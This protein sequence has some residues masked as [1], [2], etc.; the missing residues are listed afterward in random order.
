MRIYKN[1]FN[2][3]IQLL[4][5]IAILLPALM[6]NYKMFLKPSCMALLVY[7]VIF[8]VYIG[9]YKIKMDTP[10]ALKNKIL[11]IYSCLTGLAISVGN[12]I[13]FT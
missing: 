7:M 5:V 10:L 2:L 12:N 9:R 6:Q 13:E 3:V 4:G 1:K 11:V 8:V